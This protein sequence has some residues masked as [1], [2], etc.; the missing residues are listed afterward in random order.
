MAAL[1]K[2]IKLTKLKHL[3]DIHYLSAEALQLVSLLQ[4]AEAVL[5]PYV[6]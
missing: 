6:L 4:G 3:Y 1:T 5:Q 2:L